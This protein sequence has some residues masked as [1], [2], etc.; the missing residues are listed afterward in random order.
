MDELTI[1]AALK[2]LLRSLE[3]LLRLDEYILAAIVWLIPQDM[4]LKW[5]HISVPWWLRWLLV[6]VSVLVV[7]VGGL[8]YA[9]TF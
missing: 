5:S 9:G 8:L 2:R 6:G 1:V 4:L 7:T 3:W